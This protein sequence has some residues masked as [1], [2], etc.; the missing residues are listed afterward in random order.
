MQKMTARC[1]EIH[2]HLRN[3]LMVLAANVKLYVDPKRQDLFM[4]RI[5]IME[6]A[7]DECP[8]SLF[9]LRRGRPADPG[10][11]CG[12]PADPGAG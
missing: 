2:H 1:N 3:G 5:K 10:C 11:R 6:D 12:R 8:P 7:L 4:D 9:E